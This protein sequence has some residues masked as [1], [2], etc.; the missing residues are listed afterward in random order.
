MSND[1]LNYQGWQIRIQFDTD[2][3]AYVGR[4]G[5]IDPVTSRAAEPDTEYSYGPYATYAEAVAAARAAID[6]G[7]T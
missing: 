7:L 2:Y 3:T 4:L 5:P 1:Y 6:G